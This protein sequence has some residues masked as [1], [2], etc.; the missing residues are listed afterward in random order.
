LIDEK[1]CQ[2][3]KVN[4]DDE[5]YLTDNFIVTHNTFDG[6]VCILDEAQNC[7]VGQLKLFLTRLGKFSKMIVTGDPTQTDLPWDQSGLMHVVE[8][9]RGIPGVGIIEFSEKAIVRHP[10]VAEIVKRI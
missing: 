9:T 8:K 6:S 10:L 1:E 3:I 7:T 2:C 4:T 5:L